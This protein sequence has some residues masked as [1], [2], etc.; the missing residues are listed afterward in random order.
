MD[1]FLG[2]A[3]CQDYFSRSL[4]VAVLEGYDE[5]GLAIYGL[6]HIVPARRPRVLRIGFYLK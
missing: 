3:R 1:R 4:P 2:R 5:P 6:F